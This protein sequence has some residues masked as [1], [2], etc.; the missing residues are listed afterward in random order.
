MA[1]LSHSAHTGTHVKA[2][3]PCR[4]L[5]VVV[6]NAGYPDLQTPTLGSNNT[7]VPKHRMR[8]E[9]PP[10]LRSRHVRYCHNALPQDV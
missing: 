10:V 5:A 1:T 9:K 8:Q 7:V 2:Y 4:G 6:R 3:A